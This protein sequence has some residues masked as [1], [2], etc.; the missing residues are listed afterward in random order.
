MTR[1]STYRARRQG[2]HDGPNWATG[3]RQRTMRVS[4]TARRGAAAYGTPLSAKKG[5]NAG[6]PACLI[7][8]E[9]DVS[10]KNDRNL[11]KSIVPSLPQRASLINQG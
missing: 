9:V 1:G 7:G 5:R 6:L 11:E 10:T 2:R 3:P 4:A 8:G